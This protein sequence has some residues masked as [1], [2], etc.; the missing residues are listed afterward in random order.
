MSLR[1][2][3]N[4][5]LRKNQTKTNETLNSNRSENFYKII[6]S[7]F[8]RYENCKYKDEIS[9]V[10]NLLGKE[11]LS[12]EDLK[13]IDSIMVKLT[14]Y[15]ESNPDA[16]FMIAIDRLRFNY[17]AKLVDMLEEYM[18]RR[19]TINPK[20]TKKLKEFDNDMV[21][22]LEKF[23]KR[24]DNKIARLEDGVMD[25]YVNLKDRY[26]VLPYGNMADIFKDEEENINME[27]VK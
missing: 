7:V 1:N 3:L 25:R 14:H 12:E 18:K 9:Q 22:T 16:V 23:A 24:F 8:D 2:L 11:I 5:F 20:R 27:S 13:C 26:E 19:D 15:Y 4:R 17:G 6:D 21:K 10:D